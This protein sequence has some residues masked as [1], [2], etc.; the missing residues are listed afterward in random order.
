M[1]RL[2]RSRVVRDGS[3][4]DEYSSEVASGCEDEDAAVGGEQARRSAEKLR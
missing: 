2:R 1:K 3:Q 4:Q